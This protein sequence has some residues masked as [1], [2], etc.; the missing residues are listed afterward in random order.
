MISD[1][2]IIELEKNS[3]RYILVLF[4]NANDGKR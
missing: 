4:E 1:H 3:I 2:K